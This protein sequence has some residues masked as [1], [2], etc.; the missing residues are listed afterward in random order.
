MPL[1]AQ[2]EKVEQGQY[3]ERVAGVVRVRLQ[4]EMLFRAALAAALAA[5]L[6]IVILLQTAAAVL[7]GYIIVELAKAAKAA[8]ATQL[9]NTSTQ[10]Y[11]N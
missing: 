8:M 4:Q 5:V 6:Y 9:L 3:R 11:S 10:P 2:Q 1:T 7:A